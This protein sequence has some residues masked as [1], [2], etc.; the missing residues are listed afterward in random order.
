MD[1]GIG[2]GPLPSL[3]AT[4]TADGQVRFRVWAPEV[5]RVEAV[6]GGDASILRVPLARGDDGYHEAVVAGVEPGTHYRYLVDGAGPFP[7]PCSRWQPEGPH[8]PSA[9]VDPAVF[10]WTDAHWPGLSPQGLVIY[11]LH[12]GT[13]TQ[14]GT[15]EA[16]ISELPRLRRLG[17]TAIELMPV[18]EFPGMRNWGYDGVSLFAPCHVYGGPEGL[19]RL[20]DAAHAAGLGVLLD[21]VYNHLGPDGNYLGVYSPHYFTSRHKTPWGDA[22]N[23]DGPNSRPV[24]DFV[25]SNACQWLRDYHIDGLRLDAVHAIVDDSPVHLLQELAVRGREAAQPR[26]VV[27]T[28]ESDAN[29]VRLIRSVAG[30]GYGL[31][32]VW[33]DDFHHAVRVHLTGEREGYYAGFTGETHEIARAVAEG[34]IYQG[35]TLP[36]SR[37]PRGSRVTDE[38]AGAFVFCIQNHDQVGNRAEGE[39]LARLVDRDRYAAA[40]ALLLLAP[41]TPLLFMGQEYAAT[42]PFLYFTDHHPELGR[43]VT[44]GRREEFAGFAAFRDPERRARIPDPQAEATFLRSKLDPEERERNG[45]MERLYR[46]LLALRSDDPVLR[47]QDRARTHAGAPAEGVVAV[48]RWNGN[49]HRL[50]LVNFGGHVTVAW[51]AIGPDVPGLPAFTLQW[52][53]RD[54]RYGGDGATADA[55]E[56]RMLLPARS[57]V[58]L[59]AGG[60]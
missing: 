31:D 21:V 39:R 30:G 22:L 12:T 8:G 45:A 59:R 60:E 36:Q 5:G 34:F 6:I 32:A 49:S 26:S 18:A 53:S 42:T 10:G 54:E 56:D 40:S 51:Q 29:D 4:I 3:G 2:M 17:V 14:A 7:D 44:E 43:L 20:V 19:R 25:I 52:S 35:Q 57:A 46:D 27:I 28:A 58:L 37:R 24:R 47:L 48:H 23:Y 50:L 13:F 1:N 33:S 16:I 55:A 38:P 9:V 11:E 15:F 41:E